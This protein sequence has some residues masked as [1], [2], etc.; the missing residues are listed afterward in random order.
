GCTV[1]NNC[2]FGQFCSG[3]VCADLIANGQPCGSSTQCAS[4]YC[5]DSVCCDGPCAGQCESCNQTGSEGVCQPVTGPPTGIRPPCASEGP[6]CGGSCDGGTPTRRLYP[7]RGVP[8]R[9]G[10]CTDGVATLA[11]TC[12]GDGACPDII[13]Q[14]CGANA[15]AGTI[16]GNG[17]T[18]DANCA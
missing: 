15:C 17:C 2:S 6:R 7:E 13:Y 4:S 18:T 1:D 9:S 5:V 14:P 16:C 8:C 11:T 3:G 12:S 10:S